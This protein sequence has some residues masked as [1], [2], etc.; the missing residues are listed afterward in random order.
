MTSLVSDACPGRGAAERCAAEPGPSLHR[1]KWAPDQQRTT[2]LARRSAPRPGHDRKMHAG[3]LLRGRL[4]AVGVA[5]GAACQNLFGNQAGVLADR[6]F[7]LGGDVG[8]GLE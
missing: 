3:L 7:D 4:L 2:P 5:L 8:I 6:G 1:R